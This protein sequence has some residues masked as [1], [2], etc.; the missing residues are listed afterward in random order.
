MH[1]CLKLSYCYRKYG[2]MRYWNSKFKNMSP[3]PLPIEMPSDALELAKMA[4]KQITGAD[5]TSELQ[6]FDVKEKLD[7]SWIVSGMSPK[8]K[9]LL[10]SWPAVSYFLKGSSTNDV[11]KFLVFFPPPL[12][13]CCHF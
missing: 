2:R 7:D 12:P 6:I 1:N 11:V 5:P 8:Q 9:D 4:I 10:S 3:Y 13:L